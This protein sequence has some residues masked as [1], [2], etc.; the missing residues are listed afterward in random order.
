[1]DLYSSYSGDRFSVYDV[2]PTRYLL[3]ETYKPYYTLTDVTHWSS[4]NQMVL[5]WQITSSSS[6]RRRYLLRW[7]EGK[8]AFIVVVQC[9]HLVHH[10]AD[11]MECMLI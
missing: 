10:V 3:L 1:M 2:L 8:N 6:Y 4:E 5:Y 9:F 11:R 7:Y